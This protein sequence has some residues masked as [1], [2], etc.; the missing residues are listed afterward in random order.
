MILLF[1]IQLQLFELF[2]FY[3]EIIRKHDTL[4]LFYGQFYFVCIA[5]CV[6]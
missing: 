3:N 5:L 4:V 6:R 1:M 2:N